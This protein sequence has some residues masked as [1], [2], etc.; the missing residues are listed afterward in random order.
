MLL[1]FVFQM[2]PNFRSLEW[3][4]SQQEGNQLVDM[5]C[6]ML[7]LSAGFILSVF[8]LTEN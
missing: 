5:L 6:F 3:T 4:A 2:L 7:T 1:L 8:R